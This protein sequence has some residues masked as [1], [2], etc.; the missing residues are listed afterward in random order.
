MKEKVQLTA[1]QMYKRNQM[2]SKLFKR[3]APIVFWGFLSLFILF[4]ILTVSNSWGNISEIISMLDKDIYTG[5]QLSQN[6]AYLV[7]KYGEWVIAGKNA[8]GFSVQFIDIRKAFFSGLMITYLSLA[9]VCLAIAII[10]GKI[11]LPKLAQYYTDNNQ[12]MVNMATLQTNAEIQKRK[13]KSNNE[14]WF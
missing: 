5:E 12:D 1:E 9:V 10:I 7:E 11:L 13:K 14:E 8:G 2:R 3:L 4:V 6:Y